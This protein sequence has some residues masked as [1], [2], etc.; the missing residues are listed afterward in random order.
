VPLGNPAAVTTPGRRTRV[1]IGHMPEVVV[2]LPFVWQRQAEEI[3]RGTQASQVGIHYWPEIGLRMRA[4]QDNMG[5]L[6]EKAAGQDKFINSAVE[7]GDHWQLNYV[8]RQYDYPDLNY[9]DGAAGQTVPMY[10]KKVPAG[11]SWDSKLAA[12]QA[13]FPGPSDGIGA[14]ALPVDRVFR[15]T[16]VHEPDH[17]VHLLAYLPFS[18]AIGGIWGRI[19]VSGPPGVNAAGHGTGQ[20]SCE[21]LMDGKARLHERC[22]VL[23]GD[24]EDTGARVWVRRDEFQAFESP[25][26]DQ[27]Y[28]LKILS[29][30]SESCGSQWRG[31]RMVFAST[32]CPPLYHTNTR[33]PGS[34]GVLVAG[35]VGGIGSVAMAGVAASAHVYHVP[36]DKVVAPELE[37]LRL[38]FRRDIRGLF[39][40]SEL[41]Y[42]TEVV[43]DDDPFTITGFPT[44]GIPMQVEWYGDFPDGADCRI[45]LIDLTEGADSI[46][47]GGVQIVH[48]C[49][50]GV[51]EYPMTDFD[52][53]HRRFKARITLTSDGDA[54]PTL[55]YYRV[56][57]RGTIE[58]PDFDTLVF[59]TARAAGV[60]LLRQEI[61]E[62]IEVEDGTDDPMQESAT[63]HIADF[64]AE[65][66]EIGLRV[67]QAVDIDIIDGAAPPNILT[68]LARFYIDPNRSRQMRGERPGTAGAIAA[69]YPKPNS[70]IYTLSGNGEAV[71]LRSM[72]F[73]ARWTLAEEPAAGEGTPTQY[74]KVTDGLATAFEFGGYSPGRIDVPDKPVRFF[75]AGKDST[76]IIVEPFS[77]VY[78]WIVE[79]ARD[80]LGAW[81]VFDLN[82]GASG[83][84]RIIQQKRPPYNVVMRFTGEHPGALKL[85]HVLAS[86]PVDTV[87]GGPFDGQTI[88]H[89]F[90]D[91]EGD[92][93]HIEPPE[94]NCVIVQGGLPDGGAQVASRLEQFIFNP[95]SCNFFN[96]ASS[97][98]HYPDPNSP[99][100][101][102]GDAVPIVVIDA[103]LST[104]EAVNWV[105]RRVFD[106]ACYAREYRT[107]HA[108]LRYIV[109]VTDPYQTYPRRVR[110]GDVVEVLQPD[111]VT[112]RTYLVVRCSPSYSRDGYQFGRYELV[113]SS[114]MDRFGMP[115]GM[116]DLWTLE[117]MRRKAIDRRSGRNWR[118]QFLR[119]RNRS[120]EQGASSMMALP[121]GELAPAQFIDPSQ[122]NFGQFKFMADYDPVP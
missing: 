108:P 67:R 36:Q 60:S 65:M 57:R 69:Q 45:E 120:V 10:Q 44:A 87:S 27:L 80:Y 63:V 96:L 105:G 81:P 64:T 17:P 91:S 61:V 52:P 28:S 70:R 122:P 33:K 77:S 100:F 74:M 71:R 79:N 58:E 24:G 42:E 85:P 59:P 119:T 40:I 113:S 38:D 99:E 76:E 4:H 88:P 50:G 101:M 49:R 62:S 16:G 118:S 3:A 92:E 109:D 20:Y 7:V 51:I 68:K 110:F 115:V 53:S 93:T 21:L 121:S 15:T 47:P 22:K 35:L 111:K 84:W 112:W 5:T 90:I 12:D 14:S 32:H 19:Y 25:A 104:G 46:I 55:E 89:N 34:S 54:C 11:G 30:A 117:Q 72:I 1:T 66:P 114:V 6:F 116:F 2:Q 8:H 43:F 41:S 98:A 86:Y 106:Y 82:A 73:P 39:A 56:V 107:F 29:N 26:Q 23:D 95:V 78:D 75:G 9:T 102:G 13:A 97:H 103:T 18:L 94:G 83:M 31:D 37:P 48:D